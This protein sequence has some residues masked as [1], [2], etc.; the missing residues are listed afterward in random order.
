[1]SSFYRLEQYPLDPE[2]Q[3]KTWEELEKIP[4]PE[5]EHLKPEAKEPTPLE[6]ALRKKTE[7]KIAAEKSATLQEVRDAAKVAYGLLEEDP[8]NRR[9]EEA[10][11]GALEKLPA[12]EDEK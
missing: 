1:M 5:S 10:V 8:L 9:K 11:K 12:S 4:A 6:K 2:L 3:K 7:E